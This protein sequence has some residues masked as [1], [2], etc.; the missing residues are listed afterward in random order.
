MLEVLRQIFVQHFLRDG[1]NNAVIPTQG[2][3]G[4]QP[5]RAGQRTNT[6]TQRPVFI[7]CGRMDNAGIEGRNF[8]TSFTAAAQFIADKLVQP[9]V[10][11]VGIAGIPKCCAWKSGFSGRP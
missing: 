2:T 11:T 9:T 10:V 7:P 4:L 1:Q 3:G 6:V 8:F 5:L